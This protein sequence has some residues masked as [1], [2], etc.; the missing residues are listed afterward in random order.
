MKIWSSLRVKS[1]SILCLRFWIILSMLW[2]NCPTLRIPSTASFQW[3]LRNQNCRT[4]R[5]LSLSMEIIWRPKL[6]RWHSLTQNQVRNAYKF[7][8]TLAWMINIHSSSS[9]LN[10]IYIIDQCNYNVTFNIIQQRIGEIFTIH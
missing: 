8:N 10:I 7:H 9:T 1:T 6:H 5:L 2:P 4:T 3:R